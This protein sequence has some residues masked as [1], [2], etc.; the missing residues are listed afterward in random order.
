MLLPLLPMATKYRVTDNINIPFRILP[1]Y[2]ENVCVY[3][4]G[5]EWNQ[6][7]TSLSVNVKLIANFSKQVSS[8]NVELKIPV[9]PNTAEIVNKVCR[10]GRVVKEQNVVGIVQ[11]NPTDSCIDW[12]MKKVNGGQEIT[13]NVEVK[14]LKQTISMVWTSPPI[15]VN[16][17]VPMF[18]ASGLHVRFLKVCLSLGSRL[19]VTLGLRAL[20][21]SD[22]KVGPLHDTFW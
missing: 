3:C 13:L 4:G 10:T 22:H 21:L 2:E 5:S 6:S 1:N 8:Q 11:Y 12:K 7:S 14:L 18:T 19:I 15:S 9:P 16:F 17:A 20:L